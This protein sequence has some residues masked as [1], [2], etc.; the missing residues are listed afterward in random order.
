MK[1]QITHNAFPL[2]QLVLDANETAHIQRGSMIYHD[3]TIDL[4]SHLNARKNA[5]GFGR[6]M[7]TIGRAITSGENSLITEIRSSADNSVC[8]IATSS[9]GNIKV[10][11]L[12]NQQYFINDGKFLAMSEN[13][14]YE[15]H[16]QNFAKGI[17]SHTGGMFIMET[18]G[19]GQVVVN[20]FGDIYRLPLENDSMTID[21][22]HVVAWST[23]L[24][25]NLHFDN[26]FFQSMGTG[27]GLVNTFTGTGT[28]YIQS[29]SMPNFAQTLIP[30]LPTNNN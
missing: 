29:L 27:E 10:L 8:G 23:S 14:S 6:V 26:G 7:S 4:T 16:R 21:N 19:V 11:N 1:V 9:P 17:F 20:G 15:M 13:A 30:Y 28:I 22:D 12:A 2:C 25:Y 5:H 18:S 3:E 24:T